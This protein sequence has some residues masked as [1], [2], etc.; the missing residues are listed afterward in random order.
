MEVNVL[1][2]DERKANG[3][4]H[5]TPLAPPASSQHARLRDR[6]EKARRSRVLDLE[7]PGTGLWAKFSPLQETKRKQIEDRYV[8]SKD[9]DVNL[10]VSAEIV[11]WCN[12]GIYEKV[13]GELV[14]PAG[15]DEAPTFA[16]HDLM[17][18][19]DVSSGVEAVL[20]LYPF[21]GDVM[22]AAREIAV[23]SGFAGPEAMEA[24]RGN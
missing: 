8:R 3:E 1:P 12:E 6:V 5:V 23:F 10:R 20:A 19:L 4:G 22:G 14:P 24:I 15:Y 21:D 18:E 17:A 13:N 11:A 16:S 7:I 2:A 9:A